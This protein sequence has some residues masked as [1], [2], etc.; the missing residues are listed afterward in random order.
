MSPR[1]VTSSPSTSTPT[2]ARPPPQLPARAFSTFW[3]SVGR[4]SDCRRLDS[5]ISFYQGCPARRSA[6]N[7]AANVHRRALANQFQLH[8]DSRQGRR[9]SCDAFARSAFLCFHQT[10]DTRRCTIEFACQLADLSGAS[11][12]ARAL[13]SPRPNAITGPAIRSMRRSQTAR[14]WICNG[15]Q[16]ALT[17]AIITMLNGNSGPARQEVRA[18]SAY[19]LAVAAVGQRRQRCCPRHRRRPGPPAWIGLPGPRRTDTCPSCE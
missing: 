2:R 7:L 9:S 12:G 15:Q 6:T 10:P 11:S 18:A 17:T 3:V 8:L 1:T 16:R 19:R 4:F 5:N 14:H 13:S